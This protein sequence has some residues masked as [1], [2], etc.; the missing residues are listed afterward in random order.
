MGEAG[1]G[2]R[3][4]KVEAVPSKKEVEV[5][6]LAHAVFRSW[7][8]H[9]VKGRAKACGRKKRGGDAPTVCL[10]HVHA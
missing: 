8:P 2:A 7:C 5:P 10:D 1:V 6:N 9:C 3:A 4:R